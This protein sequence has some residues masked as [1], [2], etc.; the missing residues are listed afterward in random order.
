MLPTNS[1][2]ESAEWSAASIW[3]FDMLKHGHGDLAPPEAGRKVDEAPTAAPKVDEAPT[4]APTL[5][6]G[7]L[8]LR[9]A[10]LRAARL[11]RAPCMEG[12][13][14]K[15]ALPRA[16]LVNSNAAKGWRLDGAW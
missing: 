10:G 1:A 15:V 5:I 13:R 11:L 14:V 3:G 7:G 2:G 4:A 6:K 12:K 16:W 8:G 9:T